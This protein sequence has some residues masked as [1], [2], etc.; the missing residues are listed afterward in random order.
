V[1]SRQGI[2]MP[3]VSCEGTMTSN[4]AS[5]PRGIGG[6]TTVLA[7]P[8]GRVR[9]VSRNLHHAMNYLYINLNIFIFI[10]RDRRRLR[11]I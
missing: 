4:V 5:S 7:G 2:H 8:V 6:Q 9:R 3:S 1:L 11:E 10:S